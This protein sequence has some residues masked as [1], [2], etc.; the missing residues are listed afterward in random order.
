M[1]TV[2]LPQGTI[3]YREEGAGPPVVFVHGLLTNAELWRHEV[4]PLAA[5]GLRC[6]VPTWPLGAHDLPMR[7]EAALDPQGAASL[8]DAFLNALDLHDVTLVASDT[9][10][11]FTQILMA[12]MPA[13]VGRVVLVSCDALEVFFPQPFKFL[14]K[15]AWLPGAIWLIAQA[16]R[17]RALHRLPIV[18]GFVTKRPIP[19]AIAD[20]YLTPMRRSRAIRRDLGKVL[21]G[22]HRRHTLAAFDRLKDFDRPVL[23]IWAREERLFPLS[24]AH[25][26]AERLPDAR[27]ETVTDSYTLITEDRPGVVADL[28]GKFVL[29]D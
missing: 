22:I 27:L 5:A 16:T 3:A 14:P 11:A 19:A 26:L 15:L 21:R 18:F 20:S 7:P 24:L 2:T 4:P 17:L 12:R 29:P 25:R 1:K 13:R 9:G 23:L 6:I 8:I 10:G 28:V